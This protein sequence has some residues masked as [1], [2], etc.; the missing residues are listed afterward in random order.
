LRTEVFDVVGLRA[1]EALLSAGY[2]GAI[3]WIDPASVADPGTLGAEVAVVAMGPWS[4]QVTST[5]GYRVPL[6]VKNDSANGW[7]DR[8][9]SRAD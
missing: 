8:L 7:E 1:A 4:E 5:L 6:M 2:A 9:I 3:H